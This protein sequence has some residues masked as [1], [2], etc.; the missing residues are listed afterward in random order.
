MHVHMWRLFSV[1]FPH[2]LHRSSWKRSG[3]ILFI[4]RWPGSWPDSFLRLE[5]RLKLSGRCPVFVVTDTELF[6][7]GN[8]KFQSLDSGIPICVSFS[9]PEVDLR[10]V[11]IV[12]VSLRVGSCMA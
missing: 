6:I 7:V 10:T 5:A 12:R 3:C 1:C 4:W 9:S 2:S 11:W 8:V